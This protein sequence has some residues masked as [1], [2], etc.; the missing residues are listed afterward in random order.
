MAGGES[1]RMGRPKGLAQVH[2]GTL[3]EHAIAT[4]RALGIPVRLVMA[5]DQ[6]LYP[7]GIPVLR[8]VA[9]GLGP[10]GGLLTVLRQSTST[11]KLILACD[12]PRIGSDLYLALHRYLEGFD[13]VAPA[14]SSGRLH[15]LC[16]IY[17]QTC[18]DE[19]ER[20]IAA[21]ELKMEELLRS[22]QIRCRVV[23]QHE[24]GLADCRFFNV[25]TPED[26]KNL[27][28]GGRECQG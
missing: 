22:A 9:P 19:V 27:D 15:P 13:A 10:M 5:A 23:R 16:A 18:L 1:R 21:G 14:D 25:N 11:L 24:H 3:L 6:D 20:R 26:L 8:D 2:G 12:L 7:F 28:A 17:K 4:F